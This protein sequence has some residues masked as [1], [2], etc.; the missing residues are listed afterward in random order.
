M[1]EKFNK[2]LIPPAIIVAGFLIAGAIIYV[3][4]Q[5][6]GEVSITLSSQQ[7][8][9]KVI[10]YIDE[11]I[12]Q[13]QATSSLKEIVEE[14]G[15]YKIIIKIGD[16][17]FPS[18]VSPDG[19][20]LFPEVINLEEQIAV[21]EIPEETPQKTRETEKDEKSLENF[22]KCLTQKGIKFYGT[23]WCS[24]CEKQ[25]ELF[26]KA[27]QY[28]PYVECSEKETGEMT[29]ECKKAN[30]TGFPTW[31]LPNGEKSPGFKPLAKLAKLSG[32]PLE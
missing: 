32:C 25:K 11:N 1:V 10:K 5:K 26:G 12:L 16:Q 4:Q 7:I 27:A 9:E 31:Q 13:G 17:E 20:L 15:L 24:W 29:S 23:S 2:N 3:N 8:G 18:Y 21:Q 30:I 19:K 6:E 14:N 22:A 28:L